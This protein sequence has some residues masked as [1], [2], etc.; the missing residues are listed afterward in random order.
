MSGRQR[1]WCPGQTLAS[2]TG[3]AASPMMGCISHGLTHP[4]ESGYRE[5]QAG[6]QDWNPGGSGFPIPWLLDSGSLPKRLVW[7]EALG[8]RSQPSP[9]VDGHLFSPLPAFVELARSLLSLGAG[10]FL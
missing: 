3:G 7:G 5:T 1:D 6:R 9:E 8:H 10:D 2:T 4:R